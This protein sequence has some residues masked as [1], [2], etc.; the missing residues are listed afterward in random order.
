MAYATAQQLPVNPYFST[1]STE[2]RAFCL[3]PGMEF[4]N[5]YRR[6]SDRIPFGVECALPWAPAP[7]RAAQLPR[8][9][10]SVAKTVGYLLLTLV[11]ILCAW[12]FGRGLYVHFKA[13]VA[14][15][16]AEKKV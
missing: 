5:T 6:E 1:M 14:Q 9:K 2:G 11:F 12:Q 3:I 15:G 16:A 7:S 13:P 4:K 10:K 8:P